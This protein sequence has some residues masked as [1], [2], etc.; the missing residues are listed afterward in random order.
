MRAAQ[1][2]LTGDTGFA[3]MWHACTLHGTQPDT[4]DHE[5]ISLR[6]LLAKGSGRSG[7]D[8]VNEGLEGPLSLTET[9]NDLAGD[10]RAVVKKNF[11][12]QA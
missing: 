11:V 4:A 12:N 6:Y 1:L 2:V 9:R 8:E 10:G 7:L 3:G 5:R